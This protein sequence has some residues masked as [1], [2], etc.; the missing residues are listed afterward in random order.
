MSPRRVHKATERG[1][2][3]GESV[4]LARCSMSSAYS[5]RFSRTP[6]CRNGQMRPNE[7]VLRER[8][9]MKTKWM[10]WNR[11]L[12]KAFGLWSFLNSSSGVSIN[13]HHDPCNAVAPS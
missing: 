4:L 7:D 10:C 5:V 3:S 13:V 12:E 8:K 2:S 6:T 9:G 11:S 1:V